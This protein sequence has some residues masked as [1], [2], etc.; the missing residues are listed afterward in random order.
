MTWQDY[1]LT[2][3]DV[4]PSYPQLAPEAMRAVFAYTIQVTHISFAERA[5]L[6]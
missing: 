5:G 1:I 6:A 3:T 4:L 2:D